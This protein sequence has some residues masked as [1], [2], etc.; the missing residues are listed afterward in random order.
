VGKKRKGEIENKK[1][2]KELPLP[3]A[4]NHPKESSSLFLRN[5]M[6][7]G[8]ETR[9]ACFLVVDVVSIV[10]SIGRSVHWRSIC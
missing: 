9:L 6:S 5:R 10:G 4:N 2:G 1:K 8:Y 7:L 3:C